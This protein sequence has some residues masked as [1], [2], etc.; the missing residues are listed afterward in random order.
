[1]NLFAVNSSFRKYPRLTCTPPIT[2]GIEVITINDPGIFT[3]TKKEGNLEHI[4]KNSD[5]LYV[6]YTS[7]TT[8]KPKGVM[9][10]HRNLVNL[11]RYQFEY[12]DI[13][14]ERVLQF[15]SISFDVSF[16]EIFSALL[17]GGS[18]YLVDEET[19]LNIPRLFRYIEQNQ[20]ETVFF[21]PSFLRVVYNQEEYISSMPTTDIQL[22]ANTCRLHVHFFI[23]DIN[24]CIDNGF[25][26]GR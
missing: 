7:G 8:G 18:L 16:Q 11:M 1:M 23:H 6:I 5:L 21:P 25:T 22:T 26:Y 17:A 13:D 24:I 9:L 20:V 10:E 19:R 2:G 4:N 14:F 12:T 15:A 3:S